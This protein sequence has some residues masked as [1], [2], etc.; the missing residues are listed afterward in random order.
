MRQYPYGIIR[1]QFVVGRPNQANHTTCSAAYD[2]SRYPYSQI[3]EQL[4]NCLRK[5]STVLAYSKFENYMKIVE[6]FVSVKNLK[7]NGILK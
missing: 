2:M 6:I 1:H 4:N 7:L 3:A 5:L